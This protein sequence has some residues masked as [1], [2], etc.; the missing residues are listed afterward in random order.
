MDAH[1]EQVKEQSRDVDRRFEAV[2]R[3]FTE[4][5]AEM[6]AGFVEAR[7][8]TD[9]VAEELRGRIAAVLDVAVQTNKTVERMASEQQTLVAALGNHEVRIQ[10]LERRRRE[11]AGERHQGPTAP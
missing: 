9:V 1:F 4:L 8:H 2:D 3:Q 10:A 5:H 6:K 7:Q 11:F